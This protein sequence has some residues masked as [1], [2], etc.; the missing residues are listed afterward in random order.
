MSP[1]GLWAGTVGPQLTVL[2]G[3]LWDL[4]RLEPGWKKYGTGHRL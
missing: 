2:F 1:I 3:M 4:E